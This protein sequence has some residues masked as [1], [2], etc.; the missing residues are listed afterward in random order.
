VWPAANRPEVLPSSDTMAFSGSRAPRAWHTASAVSG[1]VGQLGAGGGLRRLAV[2]ARPRRGGAASSSRRGVA[3]E[4]DQGVDGAP[5]GHQ[6]AGLA[7]VGEER[8]RRLRVDEDEVLQAVELHRRE[9]GEVGEPIHRHGA[10]RRARVRAGK[11]SARSLDPVALAIRLAATRA[12]ARQARPPTNSTAGSSPVR[13]AASSATSSA[14]TALG[15]LRAIGAAGLGL[16][17]P[18]HVGGQDQ[19]GDL[20]R[21]AERHGDG[22]GGVGRDLVGRGG[23]ADPGG[24]VAGHGLDVGLQLGVV[25]LVV[26]GVVTHD[27]DHRGV[28]PCGR[29]AGWP[30]RCPGRG[31]GAAAWPAGL[32]AMRA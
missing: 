4:V 23:G 22:L 5:L 17:G 26:R 21:R 28:G 13:I 3:V 29:C 14:S 24:H 15:R 12:S 7:R 9:L 6:V 27:V 31:P 32:S 20:G 1:P 30:G 18:A 8:H 25:L 19:G 16:L 11:V 10:R 2:G